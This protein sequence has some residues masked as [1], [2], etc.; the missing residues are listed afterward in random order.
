MRPRSGALHG[1]SRSSGSLR[2]T[3]RTRFQEATPREMFWKSITSISTPLS[4]CVV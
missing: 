1:P 4:S 2:S 3:S